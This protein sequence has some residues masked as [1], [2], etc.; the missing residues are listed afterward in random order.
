[1]PDTRWLRRSP[2]PIE[3]RLRVTLSAPYE[4]LAKGVEGPPGLSSVA[5]EGELSY[6]IKTGLQRGGAT[7]PLQ[8][9]TVHL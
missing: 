2:P 4:I 7:P 8:V 3:I 6:L 5:L 9:P 1:M